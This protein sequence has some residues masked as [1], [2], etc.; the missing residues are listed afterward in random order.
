MTYALLVPLSVAK[1]HLRET[2]TVTSIETISKV[3][4]ASAII[5]DYLKGR[6]VAGWL[7]GS[8][9]VPKPI[10]AATLLLLVHLNE[11]RGDNMQADRQVWEAIERLLI[12][13]RD[14]AFA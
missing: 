12:R 11:N 1:L 5:Y 2:D 10:E 7:D 14:P 8:V 13:F 4:Q 9:T 6:A 3:E